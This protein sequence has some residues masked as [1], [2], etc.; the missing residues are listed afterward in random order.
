ME[1]GPHVP[2]PP[3]ADSHTERGGELCSQAGDLQ[4]CTPAGG[5]VLSVAPNAGP[6][7]LFY[8]ASLIRGLHILCLNNAYCKMK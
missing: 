8:I 4:S 3:A 5:S 1:A 6:T 7:M 2:V